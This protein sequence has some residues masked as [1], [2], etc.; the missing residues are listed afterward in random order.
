MLTTE[1]GSE[2]HCEGQVI[3]CAHCGRPAT[4]CDGESCSHV[5]E[6]RD[7]MLPGYAT[8]RRAEVSSRR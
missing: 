6:T 5:L 4:E 7:W 1:S 8:R 3:T 2:I